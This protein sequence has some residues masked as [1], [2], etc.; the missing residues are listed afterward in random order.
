[1]IVSAFRGKI[2]TWPKINA[3]DSQS[4]LKFAD[5]LKQCLAAMYTLSSLSILN[6]SHENRKMPAKL[7]EWLINRWNR[8]VAQR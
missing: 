8:I 4:L 7:P 5:F 2:D 6:D 3:R 1:M